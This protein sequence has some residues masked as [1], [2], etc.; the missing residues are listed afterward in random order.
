MI[1]DFEQYSSDQDG[2]NK[3]SPREILMRY[4]PFLPWFLLS[5][6]ITLSLAF[7]NLRY[8]TRYFTISG[9]IQVKDPNPYSSGSTGKFD[10]I[11]LMES[12]RSLNDEIQIMRSRNMGKRVVKK[13]S[14]QTIYY[15]VGKVRTTLIYDKEKPLKLQILYVRDSAKSF[16]LMLEVI[17]D[18]SFQLGESKQ[19]ILFGQTFETSAGVFILERTNYPVPYPNNEFL[20]VWQPEEKA[21]INLVKDLKVGIS[22]DASTILALTYETE[23]PKSGVAIVNA[24]MDEYGQVG[25]EDKKRIAES[26]LDFIEEQLKDVE[27][28]LREVENSLQTFRENNK[29]Y[30]PEQQSMQMFTE[31]GGTDV[32]ITEQAVKLKLIEYLIRY[33]NDK[34]NLYKVGM[35]TLGLGDPTL[36][37]QV[38]EYNRLQIQRETLL[39]TTLPENPAIKDLEAAILKIKDDITGNLNRLKQSNDAILED[40]N[41][42]TKKMT[43]D[44]STIPLKER[45]LLDITRSQKIREELFSYLLQ[46][47]LETNIARASTLPNSKVIESALASGVPVKPNRQRIYLFAVLLGILIPGVI[48]FLIEYLNDK[49]RSREDI[50]RNTRAP[51]LGEVG[52]A[53]EKATL[54]VSKTSRKFIAEQFRILRTNLQYFLPKIDTPVILVT[55]SFSG[56]GKSFVSVNMGAVMALTGKKTVILEF[57]IRKPKISSNLN[58]K[59]RNGISNFIIGNSSI[60]ELPVKVPDVDN[61]YV[62]PCGPIPPNPAE[63]LLNERVGELMKQLRKNFDVVIIDTA[64]IGLVSDAITLGKFAD[65]TL[66]I[67]RHNYTYKK[68]LKMIEDLYNQK[69]VPNLSVIINDIAISSTFGYYSYNSYGGSYGYGYGAGYYEDEKVKMGWLKKMIKKN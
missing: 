51:I 30:S 9:N 1:N 17:N 65:A 43:A 42:K 55:S 46:K 6:A 16:N 12:D 52:H 56:E 3:V 15:S 39:K 25:L 53:Q 61:L 40:M 41:S 14:L 7:I 5:L 4:I 60:D 23:N 48:I 69:R 26:A 2:K 37:I 19:K 58:L 57:D 34:S 66:Y 36:D 22:G 49:I 59:Q 64:P 20:I 32:K 68:Q 28:E 18:Q 24:F 44:L 11:F 45:K 8:A 21:A 13:L 38:A 54:V 27:K 35:S 29:I 33:V 50:E 62:V 63:L 67:V 47:K 10:D 31:M